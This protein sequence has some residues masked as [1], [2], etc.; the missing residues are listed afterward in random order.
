MRKFFYLFLILILVFC[1][2]CGDEDS[3][4]NQNPTA[5]VEKQE[6]PAEKLKDEMVRSGKIVI[7]ADDFSN[8]QLT[9]IDKP[10]YDIYGVWDR[11]EK[12]LATTLPDLQPYEGES[13]VYLTFDDGPDDKVTPQILDILKQEEVH[14]TF[15]VLGV[16][17]EQNPE[18]LLFYAGEGNRDTLMSKIRKH[19]LEE[20]FVP[21]G[22]RKD[23]T[24]VFEHCDA[25][26]NTYP[27]SGGLMTQYAAQLGKPVLN[28]YSGTNSKVEDFTCQKNYVS[29]SDTS[30]D[31]VA[32]KVRKLIDDDQFRKS[33]A[34]D[35]RSCVI[36]ES[37]F[38]K[39]FHQCI[40]QK[41]NVLPYKEREH[42]VPRKYDINDKI[43]YENA[44]HQYQRILVKILGIQALWLCSG[45][46]I[47]AI[48][49]LLK[50]GR[51]LTVLNNNN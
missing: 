5:E 3:S 29:I 31:A 25:F 18:V 27:I 49:T 41:R 4:E 16:M 9:E 13:V 45:L 39:L 21:I 42:F 2:G 28:Y 38:N 23:I 19:G 32:S 51:M 1:A 35:I 30:F 36:G 10:V 48:R 7:A 22:Q 43:N 44:S 14:A 37:E 11:Q 47:D 17:V 40:E 34:D 26:L 15:Y 8:L 24:E 12:K 50:E 46:V 33:Y 6:N 20:S